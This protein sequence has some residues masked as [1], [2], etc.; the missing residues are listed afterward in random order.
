[1]Q[2]SLV[3]QINSAC[4][5]GVCKQELL[6]R[7]EQWVSFAGADGPLSKLMAEQAGHL[8]GPKPILARSMASFFQN[9]P[10][11]SSAAFEQLRGLFLP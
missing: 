10:G 1:M 7:S 6:Q 5:V 3:R 4:T 11:R 9:D 2:R 8:G